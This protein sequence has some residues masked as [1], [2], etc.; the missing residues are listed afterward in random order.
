MKETH[1][2]VQAYVCILQFVLTG[3][4]AHIPPGV[5]G[6]MGADN[7]IVFALGALHTFF[8]PT[9]LL[10]FEITSAYSLNGTPNVLHSDEKSIWNIGRIICVMCTFHLHWT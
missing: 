4:K 3:F 7:V 8:S 1:R 10:S 9:K 6:R 2:G 5:F